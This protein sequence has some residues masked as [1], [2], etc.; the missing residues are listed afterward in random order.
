M[1]SMSFLAICAILSL[2]V[3]VET[4]Q[5]DIVVAATQ[6]NC[7]C[8][9]LT[10]PSAANTVQ[11]DSRLKTRSSA[12][13]NYK[14]WLQFNL[15]SI[16]AANPGLKG[17]IVTATLTFT[18]TGDNTVTKPYIV[19]GLNDSAG[20]EGWSASSLTWNNAPGN[21]TD[22]TYL[23]NPSLTSANLFTGSISPG[24]G[25]TT[26]TGSSTA[27]TAFL[28]ADSDGLVT[29]IMTPGGTAYF[30]NAS[31]MH[32]PILMV[33]T[34][35]S[36]ACYFVATDGNDKSIGDINHPYKTIGKAANMAM[37]GDTIYLR[38]GIHNYS[39]TITISKGGESEHPIT[40]QN[41]PDENVILDL[42]GE[43][44]LSGKKGIALNG[45]YW[46]FKG[47]TIQHADEVGIYVTGSYN[48]LERLVTRENGDMGS[49]LS[50]GAS[51]NLVLNCDSYLN[52]DLE[53]NGEN[54]DGFGVKFTVG[55]GNEFRGCRSWS[56]ADDGF[57]FWQANNAVTV[58]NCWAFRNGVNIWND[59]NFQGD[60]QGFKLGQGTGAHTLINC[61]SYNN[62]HKG[63]DRNGNTGG[64]ITIYN[65]TG[66]K[67]LEK[68]FYFNDPCTTH[69]YVFRNNISY[70][71]SITITGNFDAQHN[72]WNS[73]FSVSAAD[74]ASL[75]ANGLDGP[76]GPNGELPKLRFLRLASTSALINAGINVGLPYYDTAPD[77]GAFEHIDGDCQPDGIVDYLDLKCVADNWL[78]S[79][80]G[81]CNGAD[82]DNNHMVNL[83]DF[84][85]MAENWLK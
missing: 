52:Y 41:Y 21:K 3:Q 30:Y 74:F 71:G 25:G 76:R 65:C 68:N 82:F 39:D 48:I 23:L 47:F 32:P 19:N 42:S 79:S 55:L 70:L 49:E 6:G 8:M 1:K 5:A 2:F 69:S 43:A 80:C 38:G 73:G 85:I 22:D 60:G 18:G 16:Y 54:A 34:E 29:F 61:M 15:N 44:Y 75:D 63:F 57:D 9:D 58:K 13:T 35:Y 64:G 59:P 24:D 53:S 81:T 12:N 67:N 50:T 28:N 4:L 46:H 72:S 31:S 62:Q 84:A 78:T 56:N 36:S 7:V 33:S 37:A 17:H 66:V 83:F 40:L 51:Y 11:T 14:S 77:L 45:S 20:L 27:L 26:D 10:N